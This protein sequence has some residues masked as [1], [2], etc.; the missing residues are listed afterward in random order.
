MKTGLVKGGQFGKE[1]TFWVVEGAPAP[2]PSV[3]TRN[4]PQQ[5]PID[6]AKSKKITAP[7]FEAI[8]Q[9]VMSAHFNAQ[10]TPNRVLGVPKKFDLVSDDGQII[11]DAKFYTLVR[12]INTPPAKHSVIA[13]YVWLLEKTNAK[14]RFLVFGNDP[15]VPEG[16]LRAYGHLVKN[17]EF[18]FI[19][20]DD[21]LTQLR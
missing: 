16:W 7:E 11:G 5:K 21:H 18:Y 17:I 19:S 1:W 13:E 15:R 4:L 12:G 14:R 8:A 6:D 2:K 20:S 10:L 3:P 9:R